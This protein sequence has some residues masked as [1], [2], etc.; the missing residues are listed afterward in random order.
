[1]KLNYSEPKFYTGGVPING[2]SKLTYRQKKD[3]LA[4]NWYV[5]FSYRNP[6]TNKLE[7]QTPIKAGVNHLKTK[8]ERLQFMKV[9]KRILISKLESGYVPKSYEQSIKA[10]QSDSKV[11]NIE[12]PK[13]VLEK[14]EQP[15]NEIIN[16]KP[17]TKNTKPTEDPEIS[18]KEAF[19]FALKIKKQ[20][21]SPNSYA[22]Y[23]GPLKQFEKWL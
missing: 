18:I 15:P 11:E 8:E 23:H 5:Y 20:S 6:K 2:W 17:P 22:G 21:L 10:T 14:I 16:T 7:R 19:E 3:A 12:K 9:I 13:T 1:M 4:K